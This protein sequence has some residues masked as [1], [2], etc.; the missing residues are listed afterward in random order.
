MV[1]IGVG[2]YHISNYHAFPHTSIMPRHNLCVSVCV[3]VSM[4]VYARLVQTVLCRLGVIHHDLSPKLTYASF[5]KVVGE[6]TYLFL[7]V[8]ARPPYVFSM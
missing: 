1:A 7:G 8:C 5:P 4:R 6:T 2:G 3:C